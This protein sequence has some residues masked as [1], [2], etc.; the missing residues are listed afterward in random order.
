MSDKVKQQNQ[1]K[2]T[3]IQL[4]EMRDG[5]E[6]QQPPSSRLSVH[7]SKQS[8]YQAWPPGLSFPIPSVLP[9]VTIAPFEPVPD[10]EFPFSIVTHSKRKADKT[11]MREI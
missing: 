6:R 8:I 9:F 7:V 3:G 1:R 4:H 10:P 2:S 5:M 11:S